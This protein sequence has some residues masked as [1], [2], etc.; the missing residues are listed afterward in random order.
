MVT[1]VRNDDV[2]R[3]ELNLHY[4]ILVAYSKTNLLCQ[5]LFGATA[6]SGPWPHHSRGF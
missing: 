2:K 4:V 1:E 6:T 3:W 5:L